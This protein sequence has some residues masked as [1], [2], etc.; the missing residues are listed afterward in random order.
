MTTGTL[1]IEIKNKGILLFGIILLIIGLIA[2]FYQ[3]RHYV[4]HVGYQTVTPYQSVGIILVVAGIIFIAL[5]F[6]YPS[7]KTQ[8]QPLQKA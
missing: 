1:G 3:E 4:S 8:P 6:F 7:Q 5:G 2:S